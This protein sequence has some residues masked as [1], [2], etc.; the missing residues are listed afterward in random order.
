[1]KTAWKLSSELIIPALSLM[2]RYT[3]ALT[4]SSEKG[5][6]EILIFLRRRP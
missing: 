3:E 6:G 5:D 1:M 2:L 4:I